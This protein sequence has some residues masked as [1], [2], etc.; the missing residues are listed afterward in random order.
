M[1]VRGKIIC[2]IMTTIL[3]CLMVF[4][5]PTFVF[6]S[7]GR[8]TGDFV[9]L[10]SGPGTEYSRLGLVSKG[11]EFTV[12]ETKGDWYKAD[13][14]NGVTGWIASWL[15]QLDPEKT[16]S[17]V[18]V[19]VNSL[20]VRAGAGT[21]FPVVGYAG[22]GMKLEVLTKE[23]D[24]YQVKLADDRVGYVAGW[25][26]SPET[27]DNPLQPP[28]TN[29]EQE[30]E[31]PSP[32]ESLTR[33]ATVNVNNLNLRSG[34]GTN[35]GIVGSLLR[36]T[37]L[38]VIGETGDWLKVKTGEGLEGYVAN[39]LVKVEKKNSG[40]GQ[41][42][43]QPELPGQSLGKLVVIVN[44]ANVRAANHT[45]SARLDSV[46]KG[47]ILELLAE[48]G[49]WYKIKLSDGKI[50]WIAGWLVQQVQQ[51]LNSIQIN[52]DKNSFQVVLS[53]DYSAEMIEERGTD[54]TQ[55]DLRFKDTKLGEGVA[56]EQQVN[57][58][59]LQT[60][61]ASAGEGETVVS[62][63]LDPGAEYEITKAGTELTVTLFYQITE[64][65]AVEQD[66][67]TKL[68]FKTNGPP[69][70]SGKKDENNFWLS[71]PKIKLAQGLVIP[72][73][74]N[75]SLSGI[76]LTQ[77]TEGGIVVHLSLA[78]QLSLLQYKAESGLD[79]IT[80]TIIPQRLTAINWSK[81]SG[82]MQLTLQ[83]IGRADYRISLDESAANNIITRPTKLIIDLPNT[84]FP[85]LNKT[86]NV[87]DGAVKAIRASQFT[88]KPYD[89]RV[90]ADL[91]ESNGFTAVYSPE[92][93]ELVLE[94]KDPV[95]YGKTVIIDPGHGGYDPGAIGVS[96]TREK[97]LN[98][99][100]ALVLQ[101]RLREVGANQILTRYGDMPASYA[102][103]VQSVITNNGQ[104]FVSIHHN[105][106]ATNPNASGVE[107]YYYNGKTESARLAESIQKQLSASLGIT[108]RGVKKGDFYVIR[109][110][111]E[112]VPSTLSELAFLSN[113]S[114]ERLAKTVE[115]QNNAAYAIYRGLTEYF[116]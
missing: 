37:V 96:G 16:A 4:S 61:K 100:V 89:T 12:L 113:A 69:T 32:A 64:I 104:A 59:G 88:V 99:R 66:G 111:P 72:E 94:I 116:R 92:N 58:G 35:H 20:N 26:V 95:L 65:T 105:S 80:V 82:G 93:Q 29:L 63:K 25:L 38:T 108:N 42:P 77:E 48:S 81:V 67:I 18:V 51:K 22:S 19:N 98:L 56:C 112:F 17:A 21:S 43:S 60:I 85:A 50:G 103:R 55:L 30:T 44:R 107:T 71:L 53:L 49:G 83:G 102:D 74:D 47:T 75:G 62:F 57:K 86:I 14:A 7:G 3:I 45:N 15:T 70:Y 79:Y 76:S 23:G 97:D 87:G 52:E 39:W 34:P 101:E 91:A 1:G 90:V 106:S 78:Q 24:W 68:T 114:D 11:T 73:I 10:R 110:T 46:Q 5:V 36:G 84:V 109:E 2:R 33:T 54:G 9:N 27:G 40:D 115:F 41:E 6:A 13:F 28:Q 31:Q 8:V